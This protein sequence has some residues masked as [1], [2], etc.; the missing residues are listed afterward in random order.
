MNKFEVTCDRATSYED[1]KGL[2]RYTCC[3]VG[4]LLFHAYLAR[5]HNTDEIYQ[6]DTAV[7]CVCGAGMKHCGNC[8]MQRLCVLLATWCLSQAY[9][10][11]RWQHHQL[12]CAS[13]LLGPFHGRSRVDVHPYAGWYPSAH[14]GPSGTCLTGNNIIEHVILSTE[15]RC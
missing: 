13:P 7:Y 15:H 8:M 6:L 4:M 3:P 1:L 10:K 5:I 14:A 9:H 12:G 11:S 2:L